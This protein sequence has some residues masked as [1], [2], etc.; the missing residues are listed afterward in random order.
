M[1]KTFIYKI[2]FTYIVFSFFNFLSAENIGSNSGYKIPR[3]LS[4]K[5]DETNLRIGA[6]LDYPIILRY[7]HK[8]IPIMIIEENEK[9]RKI[10]DIENNEG[11]IHKDLIKGD[12]Y[13]IINQPYTSNTHILDKP[14][15][16]VV[17][18]IGKRNIVKIK[19][20]LSD[21]C[22]INYNQI[23]GWI[24]KENL[25]GVFKSEEINVPSYQK[26]INFI[27]Q[28]NLW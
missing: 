28:L 10:I 11:W 20:C 25:W 13:A 16:K 12:R 7:N 26:I 9:W 19:K 8:N 6:S 22:L 4:L 23:N 18:E 3:F 1:H 21:W 2:L 15:G 5:S 24:N 17:G 27:W 14:E